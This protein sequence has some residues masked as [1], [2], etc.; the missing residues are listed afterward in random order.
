V[1][2]P[3]GVS[4]LFRRD[5]NRIAATFDEVIEQLDAGVPVLMTMELSDAFYRPDE[6]GIV[7]ATEKPDPKRKH[8]V[9]AVGHGVRAA[10]RMILTRNSWG[11]DWGIAG[12]AWLTESYL[13]PRLLRA[14]ILT[15]EL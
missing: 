15:K 10:E 2:P 1:E 12:Y 6:D 7:D 13:T 11:H 8:A 5:G 9:V 3:P 4:P 14:A